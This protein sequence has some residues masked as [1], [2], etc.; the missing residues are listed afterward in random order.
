MI[1]FYFANSVFPFP[2]SKAVFLRFY[3]LLC[4]LSTDAAFC[5][6]LQSLGCGSI[7]HGLP[8]AATVMAYFWVCA[9][10]G[11]HKG[12]MTTFCLETL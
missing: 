11:E 9:F 2:S 8:Q 5:Q 6:I 7:L 10:V 1:H 12:S 4:C 3:W